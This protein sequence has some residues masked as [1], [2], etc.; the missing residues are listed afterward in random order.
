MDMS[1]DSMG[2]MTMSMADMAMV[3][4]TSN[5][6]PLYSNAWTPNGNGQYAGT[7]I[8]LILLA[9][10]FRALLAVRVNATN[11]RAWLTPH[12]AI[13]HHE[14]S[15]DGNSDLKQAPPI[16]RPWNINEALMRAIMDTV[17]AGASYLM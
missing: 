11:L 17:L 15:Q 3:F 13:N 8:F 14:E 4:F 10:L 9:V 7:C 12:H 2:G 1:G 6:T 16:H 5:A